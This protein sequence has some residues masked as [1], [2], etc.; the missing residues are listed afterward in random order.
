MSLRKVC[1]GATSFSALLIFVGVLC[2]SAAGAQSPDKVLR[3]AARALGEKAYKQLNT[4][5]ATGTITRLRDGR[6][7]KIR[8]VT[9]RPNLYYSFTE[10]DGFESAEGYSGTSGWRRDSRDGLRTLTGQASLDFQWL[11]VYRNHLWL[12]AKKDRAKLIAGNSETIND[13]TASVITL[14]SNRNVRIRMF[15]DATSSQ[16]VREEIPDGEQTRTYDYSDFR[17]VAGVQRPHTVKLQ[18]G[19]ATEKEQYE[20]RLESITHNPTADRTLF[21]FPKVSTEPLPDIPSLLKTVGENEERVEK[22]LDNYG[23]TQFSVTREIEKNGKLKENSETEDVSFYKGSRVRRTIARNG[24]PLSP[25]DQEKEDREIEKRIR[26]IDEDLAKEE[27]E[28]QKR[29]GDRPG[30]DDRRVSVADLFSASNLINPRRERFRGR[31]VIVFDFEPNPTYK[32]KKGIEKFGGKTAGAM[33]VDPEDK[34]VVRVEARFIKSLNVGGGLLGALKEGSTFFLESTRVNDEIWLPASIEINVAVRALF[35]GFSL[36]QS[37]RYSDY[38]RF[39]V[40]AEK[41]KLKIPAAGSP[42]P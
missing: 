4:F 10:I 27:R 25:K 14:I 34:Q 3:Q 38:K 1:K 37:V 13:K 12:N 17:N 8:V 29:E 20:I 23:Y 28:K 31:E 36:N 19:T 22:L 15:F 11:A 33:W 39:N 18:I 16:L 42:R 21:D 6:T 30:E 40:D 2:V 35:V 41:E 9:M 24:Q 32:P 5:Q 26:K 7:G